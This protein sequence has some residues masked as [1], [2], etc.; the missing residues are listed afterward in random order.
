LVRKEKE[1]ELYDAAKKLKPQGLSSVIQTPGGPHIIKLKE[2]SPERHYTYDEARSF[3]VEKLNPPLIEQRT[4]EW[5]QELKKE[6]KIV[7]M[8]DTAEQKTAEPGQAIQK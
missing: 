8:L 4:R 6:A 5:E 1:K 3:I 2:F 7:L